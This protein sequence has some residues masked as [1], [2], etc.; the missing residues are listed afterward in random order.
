VELEPLIVLGEHQENEQVNE[1]EPRKEQDHDSLSQY[2]VHDAVSEVLAIV[3]GEH[4]TQDSL[5]D[6]NEESDLHHS[7]DKDTTEEPPVNRLISSDQDENSLHPTAHQ[8][9]LTTDV[10]SRSF[11]AK[12]YSD[13]DNI[14]SLDVVE[15]EW[16]HEPDDVGGDHF[17]EGSDHSS[18]VDSSI[19]TNAEQELKDMAQSCK[20]IIRDSTWI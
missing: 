20:F 7:T 18:K 11:E 2:T 14:V 4:D 8:P 3:D 1:N 6:P 9:A 13:D 12:S 10:Q 17:S 19:R 15:G 16:D 5:P